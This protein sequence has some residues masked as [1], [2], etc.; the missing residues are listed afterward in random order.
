M[1]MFKDLTIEIDE[2]EE[3]KSPLEK[4]LENMTEIE[5]LEFEF[6]W[7][8]TEIE[9]LEKE[10]WEIGLKLARLKGEQCGICSAPLIRRDE[11]E[12]GSCTACHCPF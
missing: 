10:G 11:K 6:E 1:A 7:I 12:R 4:E 2:M 9:R 3:K 5:K 8:H